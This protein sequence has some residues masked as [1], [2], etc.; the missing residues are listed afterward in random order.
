MEAEFEDKHAT[1][2][3]CPVCDSTQIEVRVPHIKSTRDKE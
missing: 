1:T 2:C 3:S